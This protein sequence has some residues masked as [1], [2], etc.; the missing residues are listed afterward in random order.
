MNLSPHFTLSEFACKCG[1]GFE[2]RPDILANLKKLA[3]KLEALRAR[4]GGKLINITSGAR[5]PK[6]NRAEGGVAN[7]PHLAGKAADI[8]IAG[9][10]P[11]Q[12]AAHAEAAG[13]GGI[14]LYSNRIHVDTRAGKYRW[15]YR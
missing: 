5:C 1:C 4:A 14:G 7:S 9:L 15:D 11:E 6:H 13:L 3:A 2:K 12:M 8:W 10:T